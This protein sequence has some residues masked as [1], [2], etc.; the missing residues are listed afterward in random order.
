MPVLH[1]YT[2]QP[3]FY[4]KC[5]IKG[6]VVT[7]QLNDEGSKRLRAA[8]MGDQDKF[9]LRLLIDLIHRGEA[10]TH[11]T[12]PS[13]VQVEVGQLTFDFPDDQEA[14]KLFPCCAN[15]GAYD[16]LHLVAPDLLGQNE[17]RILCP[18][19][20]ASITGPLLLSIPLSLLTSNGLR[21]LED[22]GKVPPS[23]EAVHSL[24]T[25]FSANK[26]VAWDTFIRDRNIRQESLGFKNLDALL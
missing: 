10:Y 6:S 1:K 24:R 20:R 11:G 23:N 5:H 21:Q 2:D 9:P 12:G 4:I 13:P 25:W 22:I 17:A 19:C 14:E 18:R 7:F 26:A 15:D 16:D 3:A 8:G